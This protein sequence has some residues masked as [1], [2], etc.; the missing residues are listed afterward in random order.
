M[1][2]GHPLVLLHAFPLSHLIWKN[3]QPPAGYQL[4][5]PD[6]PGFGQS[7]LAH[8][9][10]TLADAAE[11][12]QNNLKELGVIEPVTL[13]G[14]SMGGYWALE[15]AR[16]FPQSLK[17]LLLIST[18]AGAD[19]PEGRQKR[20]ASAEKVEE[21]GTGFLVDSMVPG[22][23]GKT[24]MVG[25][26]ALVQLISDWIRET[27]PQAVSLAQRAMANR[28]DQEDL[29]PKVKVKTLVLA[30]KEDAL[31]PFSESESMAK[32]IPNS[33]LH[34]LDHVGHLIPLEDPKNFQKI[35]NGFLSA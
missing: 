26:K 13:G 5:L 31:I 22:L 32:T 8:P 4:I 29:L 25:N 6:F 21:E 10:F 35:L 7:P 1:G 17:S 34:L 11:S 3:L 23:L 24:T 14:I 2:S 30:G 16:Q 28:R 19:K 18:R 20:L 33:Q 9:G 15:F 27:P 12:L